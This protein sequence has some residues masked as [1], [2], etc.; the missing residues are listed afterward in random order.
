M[1]KKEATLS[2][3]SAAALLV[4]VSRRIS[5]GAMP[6]CKRCAMRPTIVD[7]FPVPAE[8][9]MRLR[10]YVDVAASNCSWLSRLSGKNLSLKIFF[11]IIAFKAFFLI[12]VIKW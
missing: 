2:I 4:N 11:V 5:F 6:F 1:P 12:I 9:M 7:V 10:L 3:I 8:A